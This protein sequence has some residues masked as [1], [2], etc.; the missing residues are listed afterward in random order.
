MLSAHAGAGGIR[1]LWSVLWSR[2]CRRDP[3]EWLWRRAAWARRPALLRT[4]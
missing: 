1:W 4:P 2:R 3:L